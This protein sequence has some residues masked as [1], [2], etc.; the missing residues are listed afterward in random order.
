MERRLT[1]HKHWFQ[2]ENDTAYDHDTLV[3]AQFR[4]PYEWLKAMEHV[5]H[6]SPAHLRTQPNIDMDV[7]RNRSSAGND[8][9]I[10]LTKPW[11]T[12]RVGLDLEMYGNETCQ[13]NFPYKDIISCALEP[14]PHSYYNWT[15]RYSEHQ[16]FYE[17]KVDGSG[18]PYQNI[19]EMRSDKIRNHLNVST[20]AGIADVWVLQYEYLVSE[21]TQQL[22]DRIEQWTGIQPHCTAKEPQHRQPKA[23]RAISSEF[24]KF[25]REH[26]NWTTEALIGYKPEFKREH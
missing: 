20:Y 4:N 6:H 7:L 2:H 9:N 19:M 17:M 12:A 16:P 8:W 10:F 14:Y 24:A 25:V 15:I 11:T 3:L 1:R 22:L 13:D 5:P 18:L 21:G 23:S 26:L